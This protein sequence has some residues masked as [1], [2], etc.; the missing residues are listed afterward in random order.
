MFWLKIE[1]YRYFLII[2]FVI[3][4]LH[5]FSKI[6]ELTSNEITILKNKLDTCWS[7]P[8]L[9]IEDYSDLKIDVDILVNKNRSVKKA[10]ISNQAKMAEK[11]YRIAAELILKSLNSGKCNPLPLPI[12]K[13]EKWKEMRLTYDFSFMKKNQIINQNND[14]K[15][16]S[17]NSLHNTVWQLESDYKKINNLIVIINSYSTLK[18]CRK[19]YYL[20]KGIYSN[21]NTDLIYE[22]G[23]NSL[24]DKN[25]NLFFK[26][27]DKIFQEFSFMGKI[28]D[29]EKIK[30]GTA[31]KMGASFFFE[32]NMIGKINDNTG[33]KDKDSK[34][35]SNKSYKYYTSEFFN[36]KRH[37]EFIQKALTELNFYY[38]KIDGLIGPNTIDSIINWKNYYNRG[39]S[40]NIFTKND[41]DFLNSITKVQP[42]IYSAD[43]GESVSE[44]PKIKIIE[45]E[46]IVEKEV[47][48]QKE[49]EY[50]PA[51]SGSGFF[52][53][54]SGILI[55]NHHV[56]DKCDKNYVFYNGVKFESNTIG[57]DR[58]NDL[59]ILKSDLQPKSFYKIE[60]KDVSLL[61]DVIVAGYPLGKNI[62]ASIKTTKGSI[63]SLAGYQ[64]NYSNFQTDAALNQG[65]SGGPII[66]SKGNIV[67][68]AVAAFGKDIGIESFNF[69]IKSSV[70]KTFVNSFG[71]N[72]ENGDNDI[73]SN[74]ELGE[75][76][77]NSTVYLECWM[78]MAK[79]EEL[80]KSENSQKAFFTNFQ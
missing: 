52:I 25:N 61:D 78:T 29:N 74:K 8:Q 40:K 16:K 48:V 13:Y 4:P 55:T 46:V 49:P 3:F 39:I 77:T 6:S 1:N 26:I 54:D 64:D 33:S 11:K 65:N 66:N 35:D 20:P 38:F 9:S 73:K 72:F 19:I 22:C 45:K 47:Y 41:Y 70:L 57:V 15:P 59:A 71:I 56:I 67:G 80:I 76:I 53:N 62:S 51:A 18:Y 68:V 60:N 5:S 21:N 7:A 24:I 58:L 31:M 17:Y 14:E 30:N 44:Q 43:K 34:T 37:I 42:E 75:L 32:G 79:I 23:N 12:N 10:T 2:I 28:Q 63:T 27:N 36:D 50:I 69:G